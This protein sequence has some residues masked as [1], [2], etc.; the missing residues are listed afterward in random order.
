MVQFGVPAV[1]LNGVLFG[2]LHV[3]LLTLV[4]G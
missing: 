3:D 1:M 4:F 2:A